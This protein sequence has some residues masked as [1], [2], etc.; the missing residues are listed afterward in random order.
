MKRYVLLFLLLFLVGCS[1]PSTICGDGRLDKGETAETCC[2]D[3][4]CDEEGKVCELGECVDPSC[5]EC[6]YLEDGV[7]YDY[8]CCSNEDCL[9]H[10]IC[11]DNICEFFS[12]DE[13]CEYK[14]VHGCFS[15][16][17]CSDEDCD[18]GNENTQDTCLNPKT[19]DAE[20][21]YIEIEEEVEE[22]EDETEDGDLPGF[23]FEG[24]WL[25]EDN[26]GDY[27]PINE[28]LNI[29]DMELT[30]NDDFFNLNHLFAF[31]YLD[32]DYTMEDLYYEVQG[33]FLNLGWTDEGL[34][35]YGFQFEKVF[36]NFYVNYGYYHATRWVRVRFYPNCTSSTS[37]N[38]EDDEVDELCSG[39]EEGVYYDVYTSLQEA[40]ANL[41]PE[42]E[43]NYESNWTDST[44]SHTINAISHYGISANKNG[45][46]SM[47]I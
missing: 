43:I 32:Q 40:A 11:V 46:V 2:I 42:Y 47:G 44:T 21:D 39:Y 7:C 8:M 18:D 41:P 15:Y 24:V 9:D 36:E 38:V 19:E 22:E 29:Y 31:Y 16:T 12:C 17:C 33:S 45:I 30:L 1:S 3:A 27:V 14:G 13:D 6:Q 34:G 5:E 37:C 4:G 26:L 25:T 10:E 23:Y 35:E 20:C 28:D